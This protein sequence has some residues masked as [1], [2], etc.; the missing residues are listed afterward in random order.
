MAPIVS[1]E[2][3]L[4][5]A[6]VRGVLRLLSLGALAALLYALAHAAWQGLAG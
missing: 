1:P 4:D 6:L 2:N 5:A 3:V